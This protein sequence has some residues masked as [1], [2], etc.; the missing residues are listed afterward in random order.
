MEED[1]LQLTNASSEGGKLVSQRLVFVCISRKTP[2]L[3]VLSVRKL[4]SKKSWEEKVDSKITLQSQKY[5]KKELKP[6]PRHQL[7]TALRSLCRLSGSPSVK[8]C[9]AGTAGCH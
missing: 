1:S 5:N 9:D 4:V 2:G 8:P 3:S 6:N 7:F